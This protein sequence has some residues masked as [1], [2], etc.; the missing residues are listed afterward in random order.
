MNKYSSFIILVYC[1]VLG[2]FIILPVFAQFP[3]YS[4]N[5]VAI[6]IGADGSIEGD[7]S[8]VQDG[9][10]YTLTENI[11]VSR[12][13]GIINAG[14]TILK[15]NV[16][17]DGAGYSLTAHGGYI[18]MG[19]DLTQRKNV[20]I[21]NLD[22]NSFVHSF[23][24][25]ESS[26][27][28]I[29]N[30]SIIAPSDDSYQT[31]FWVRQSPN[32]NL[33]ANNITGFKEYGMLVE[34]SPNNIILGNIFTG[35]KVDL[36]LSQSE[37]NILR[38]NQ[39]NSNSNNFQV[40]ISSIFQ[41]IDTSNTIRGKPIYYWINHHDETVPL[42]A[43]FIALANCTNITI[44]NLHI[45]NN[46]AAVLIH[47]TTDSI[48]KDNVLV[49]NGAGI[50]LQSCTNMT[51]DRNI[52]VSDGGTGVEIQSS[53]NI[54]V[55]RNDLSGNK[56]G[57]EA[58]IGI[59]ISA[60]NCIVTANN[61]TG[62]TRSGIYL[63]SS[64]ENFIANNYIYGNS[65][66]IYIY[67]G[68]KNEIFQNNIANNRRWGIHLSSSQSSNNNNKIYY[69]N[70]INNTSKEEGTE[71]NLQASN[72]WYF[73][74]ETN[75]WD[76]ST[77]GNYWSDYQT[78]YP[79]ASE[80]GFS[81]IGDTYFVVN[82]NNIDHYPLMSKI[83]LPSYEVPDPQPSPSFTPTPS[84]DITSTPSLPTESPITSAT[85][86]SSTTLTTSPSCPEQEPNAKLCT[87]MFMV[88]L[89]I[90]VVVCIGLFVYFKKR[91]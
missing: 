45:S 55:T 82:E 3:E 71:G 57:G 59:S 76:N 60:T 65:I 50:S 27:N 58:A 73:G 20:T 14:I 78:R 21:K 26:S 10:I 8:I 5:G 34:N 66:G 42:D 47:S 39:F 91:R 46:S 87:I 12:D 33:S 30:N 17:L 74:P 38:N 56:I 48:V 88:A 53:S 13:A 36:H 86:S 24:L 52:I 75:I 18:D 9:N 11:I 67:M 51:L 63:S 31:G 84:P 41:D 4:L 40:R 28:T 22:I 72:P 83:S 69:N 68:G 19:I 54:S 80:I 23:W 25:S 77:V 43:G 70:F 15:D 90:I 64:T 44:Q 32:N 1:F 89:V 85:P 37:N 16:V 49:G 7:N 29:I 79:N 6:I 35:N 62:Y 61:I 81:G 2:L